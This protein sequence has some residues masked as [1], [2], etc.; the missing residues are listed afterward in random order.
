MGSAAASRAE[1]VRASVDD[2]DSI[3]TVRDKVLADNNNAGVDII[4]N[5]AELYLTPNENRSEFP[6]QVGK[7]DFIK[8]ILGSRY[9]GPSH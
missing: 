5:N 6:A 3:R 9:Q 7:T 8:Y 1:F 2:V 4:V